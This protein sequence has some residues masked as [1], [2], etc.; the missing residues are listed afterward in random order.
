MY[1]VLAE[2]MPQSRGHEVHV[3]LHPRMNDE[4]ALHYK[5]THTHTS[6]VVLYRVIISLCNIMQYYG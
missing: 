2:Q 3:H 1:A 4:K 5:Y 6:H